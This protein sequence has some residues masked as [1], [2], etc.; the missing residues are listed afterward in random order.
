MKYALEINKERSKV[1]EKAIAVKILDLVSKVL[2][3]SN[4]NTARR[5]VWE[6]IQNAKDVAY[7]ER[8]TNIKIEL[9]KDYLDFCHDGIPFTVKSILALINQVTNKDRD[10]TKVTGKF[11]T[12][13]ITTHL[14]SLVIEVAGVLKENDEPYKKFNIVLDRTGTD[15]ETIQKSVTK[16]LSILEQIDLTSDYL[17]YNKHDY[18][19]RFRYKLDSENA[20]NVALIG[21]DDLNNT[22]PFV[23]AMNNGIKNII[24]K[25]DIEETFKILNIDNISDCMS[26]T[27]ILH[28]SYK[29]IIRTFLK[30]SDN[31]TDILV[32]I[33][34][35]NKMVVPISDKTPRIFSTF[36][37]IGTE[38]FPYPV[39]INS[40]MFHLTEPR[41][42]IFLRATDMKEAHI[43][44]NNILYNS[45]P[46]LKTLI[47][48]LIN[49]GYKNLYELFDFDVNYNKVWL[50]EKYLRKYLLD[51]TNELFNLPL[52]QNENVS[53]PITPETFCCIKPDEYSDELVKLR[54]SNGLSTVYCDNEKWNYTLYKFDNIIKI[55]RLGILEEIS[56]YLKSNN[57][58]GLGKEIYKYLDKLYDILK[59]ESAEKLQNMYFYPNMYGDFQTANNIVVVDDTCNNY[60]IDALNM[61]RVDNKVNI[62]NHILDKNI[63]NDK[64]SI[65]LEN[66]DS[67]VQ[68]LRK[69]LSNEYYNSN[70]NQTFLSIEFSNKKDNLVI[71]EVCN[72]IFTNVSKENEVIINDY[73]KK[74]GLY[75]NSP[76]INR[77]NFSDIVL[78][79][80]AIERRL[81]IAIGSLIN[82]IQTKIKI[83][84]LELSPNKKMSK[85][86]YVK[87]I[88]YLH[89]YAYHQFLELLNRGLILNKCNEIRK[90][91]YLKRPSLNL[92]DLQLIQDLKLDIIHDLVCDELTDICTYP[93]Y[94]TNDLVNFIVDD[95]LQKLDKDDFQKDQKSMSVYLYIEDAINNGES[96][97]RF[98]KLYERRFELVNPVEIQKW[99]NFMTDDELIISKAEKIIAK[100]NKKKEEQEQK[101]IEELYNNIGKTKKNIIELLTENEYSDYLSGRLSLNDVI[102]NIEVSRNI[103]EAGE[104]Y[105]FTV[106]IND[107]KNSGYATIM[108]NENIWK[109]KNNNNNSNITIRREDTEVYKQSG[110]DIGI[111]ENNKLIYTV[112][113]K[114][115][116]YN[117]ME[118]NHISTNQLTMLL[119]DVDKAFICFNIEYGTNNQ[120]MQ[121]YHISS[122]TPINKYLK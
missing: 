78:I 23:I 44:N 67:F 22:M 73:F 122:E 12:G 120:R 9:N 69:L 105:I 96:P 102:Q 61:F 77:V 5:W 38:R 34:T 36:P 64:I 35:T 56:N 17:D 47:N 29:D 27:K 46:M 117:R 24:I 94:T 106:I 6:L 18:N 97:N 66:T 57:I 103:G 49:N 15:V 119:N 74:S 75:N 53:L 71:K 28:K 45:I 101:K 10:N 79:N 21:L 95:Y 11:G 92:R 110:Y 60:L 70:Y 32:E 114:T 68:L 33:D 99:K 65:K 2:N 16:T 43:V 81:S 84:D 48:Y 13:F 108:E 91:D 19:T 121:W 52:L 8:G 58:S 88:R 7:P 111:Y 51:M 85:E 55:D 1:Y 80:T 118:F 116:R 50:E 42:G 20:R 109:G 89:D 87:F 93:N 86:Q 4:I 83:D 59:L 3:E 62:Y 112:E 54:K 37:L 104:K 31:N 30:Y 39:I 26:I 115:S 25:R 72:L 63:T 82:G 40:K 113:V 98:G 100:R 14:L 76:I 41:D 90:T 107:F